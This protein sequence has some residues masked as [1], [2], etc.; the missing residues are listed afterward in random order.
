MNLLKYINE[1]KAVESLKIAEERL[2]WL[3]S[4]ENKEA[5]FRKYFKANQDQYF[6]LFILHYME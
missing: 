4:F 1:P 6:S 2:N 5:E 3:K